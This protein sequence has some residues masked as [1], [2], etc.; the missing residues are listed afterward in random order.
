MYDSFNGPLRTVQNYALEVSRGRFNG[1]R[2][3]G[4]Y[5]R[6]DTAGAVDDIVVWPGGTFYYPDQTTGEDITF[7]SSS[8]E[9]APG[10]TGAQSIE[11]HYLDVNLDIKRATI[12][13]N[14]VTPVTGQLSGVRFIQCMHV[15]TVGTAVSAVGLIEAYRATDSA[16]VFSLISAG[17]RRC[18]SS[19]RMVPRNMQ[20]VLLGMIGSSTSG[21]AAARAVIDFVATELDSHQ[22]LNPFMPIP[23]QS[24]GLQDSSEAYTSPVP[25]RFKAGTVVGFQ[26]TTDKGAVITADWVGILE[27]ITPDQTI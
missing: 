23:H 26:V 17:G 8:A 19:M 13:L 4:A 16:V 25:F 22:Y 20:L 3:I 14:G 18:S 24:L 1:S 27:D 9:D 21:T 7:V 11:V 2:P 10:G 6:V 15:E 5:G 12:A